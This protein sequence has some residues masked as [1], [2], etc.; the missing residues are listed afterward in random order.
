MIYRTTVS[1]VIKNTKINKYLLV[2][3]PATV[4][5]YPGLWAIPGGGIEVGE[6]MY[7][8]LIRECKE[9]VGLEIK[10]IMPLWF[11]DAVREKHRPDGSHDTV[12]MIFLVF[13]CET[14]SDTVTIDHEAE[15]YAWVDL[16]EISTYD[17]NPPTKE[18]F[19]KV[20]QNE[21]H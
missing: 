10:S 4:G 19:E 17:L 9:E 11:G 1:A 2:K 5:V 20:L 16:N 3:Q 6:T 15:T 21:N 13:T 14:D 8:A 12:Y 18:T 7:E